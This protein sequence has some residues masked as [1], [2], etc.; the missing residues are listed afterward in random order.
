MSGVLSTSEAASALRVSERRVR[1][2]IASGQL[3]A[4]RLLG[5]WAVPSDS[6]GQH[7][8][9]PKAGRPMSEVS[10]WALLRSLSGAVVEQPLTARMHQS[11][12]SLFDVPDPAVKLTS[13]VSRRGV[14]V[15]MWGAPAALSSLETDARVVVSGNSAVSHVQTCNS[16]R[17]Y[18]AASDCDAVIHDH[19]LERVDSGSQIPNATLWVVTDINLVPRSPSN[20]HLAAAP[21]AAIDIIEC[22]GGDA[23]KAARRIISAAVGT[24]ESF[25]TRSASEP[26]H[27]RRR[28]HAI[29]DDLSSL[30]GP[31]DSVVHL[32]I[33]LD[34]GP[35]PVYD[36]SKD[37]EVR[38]FYQRVLNESL[39]VAQLETFL[40]KEILVDLWPNLWLDREV[41]K[42]WEERF[43]ELAPQSSAAAKSV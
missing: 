27:R 1:A 7:A 29:V 8:S 37:S 31:T 16:V 18:V 21:V 9:R 22:G 42:L 5:R 36:L 30:R 6:V 28:P 11:I 34:W 24:L 23:A 35:N 13:W 4:Q 3:P 20:S 26:A 12:R 19:A 41:K 14:P 2:M 10:A 39:S 33:S 40:N 17:V 32:P 43:P 38:A 25:Y 15:R